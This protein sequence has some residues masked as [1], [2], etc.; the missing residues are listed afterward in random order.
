MIFFTNNPSSISTKLKHYI[1]LAWCLMGTVVA[2]GQL[3]EI[4]FSEERGFYDNPFTVELIADDPSAIIRYT[5][6]NTKPTTSSGTIYSSPINV[7]STTSI[8]AIAYTGAGAIPVETHTYIFL[9]DIITACLL[10]TSPSPRDLSTS[11]MPSSA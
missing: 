2:S 3:T 10:Y 5:T 11:R 1:I 6:N 8:R 4:E 7:S 9:D